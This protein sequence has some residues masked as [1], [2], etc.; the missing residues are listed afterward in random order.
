MVTTCT[1]LHH[2][3]NCKENKY[4]GESEREIYEKIN[5]HRG[6]IYRKETQHT[7]GENFNRPWH[8]LANMKV[9]VLETVK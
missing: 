1:S 5:E 6:Y 3:Y 2:V 7:T 8:S 4:I 9:T